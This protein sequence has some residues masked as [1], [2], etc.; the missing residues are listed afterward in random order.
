MQQKLERISLTP[1]QVSEIYGLSTGTLANWRWKRIGPRYYHGGSRKV[2]YMVKD[3][4][5][6]IMQ[7]P[8]LTVDS[9]PRNCG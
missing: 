7:C 4:E 2:L 9:L 5:S 8:V 6:W 1:K 3:V